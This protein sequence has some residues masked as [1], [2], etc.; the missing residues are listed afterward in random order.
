[1]YLLKGH[2]Q[3]F[4]PLRIAG[5]TI[6][7]TLP[8]IGF[9]L[10]IQYEKAVTPVEV[11]KPIVQT[12]RVPSITPNETADWETYR[13]SGFTF[14]YPQEWLPKRNA[15]G[16][17]LFSDSDYKNKVMD[18]TVVSDAFER[19]R[20]SLNQT[21]G[22]PEP[23]ASV[24]EIKSDLS[25]ITVNNKE[26]VKGIVVTTVTE[27]GSGKLIDEEREYAVLIP[28]ENGFTT[29]IITSDES[30]IDTVDQILSTFWFYDSKTAHPDILVSIR[31]VGGLCQESACNSEK[32]ILRDGSSEVV[33]EIKGALV[34]MADILELI[35]LV[36]SADYEKIRSK[37]FAGV[38]PRSYDGQEVIYTFYTYHGIEEVSSCTSE[39]DYTLPLFEKIQ[40]VLK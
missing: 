32:L 33:D 24:R 38:C 8:F 22:Y 3:S 9:V 40:G 35:E 28:V 23:G 20:E 12:T 19:V 5:M 25:P 1:M 21:L 34:D 31:Y 18:L 2:S 17:T 10:G 7:V 11:P 15:K 36:D 26:S 29:I 14:K 13:G 6:F 27:F 30:M 39:I 4:L 37:R 16:V